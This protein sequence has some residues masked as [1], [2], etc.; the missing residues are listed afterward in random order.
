MSSD[1]IA[2]SPRFTRVATPQPGDIVY[3]PPGQVP[4]QLARHQDTRHY[5]GHVAIVTAPE[6]FVGKQ[7]ATGDGNV[8]PSSPSFPWWA[9]RPHSY[10][11]YTGGTP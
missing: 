9:S 3:F 6:S 7:S 1:V 10:L 4:Y 8:S 2:S 11:R 5:P